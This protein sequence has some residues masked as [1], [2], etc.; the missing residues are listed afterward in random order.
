MGIDTVFPTRFVRD[1]VCRP[2]WSRGETE[3]D[4]PQ[5]LTKGGRVRPSEGSESPMG[6]ADTPTSGRTAIVQHTQN[7]RQRHCQTRAPPAKKT[8][9][10]RP[11]ASGSPRAGARVTARYPR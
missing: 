8:Q 10:T 11:P 2:T 7:Q 1:Q 6:S 9:L 5:R 3:H 4:R